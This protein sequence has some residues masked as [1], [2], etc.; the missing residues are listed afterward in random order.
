MHERNETM[1]SSKICLILAVGALALQGQ[2]ATATVEVSTVAELT[3]AVAMA[4]AGT[5][6]DGNKIGTIVLKK[7]GSFVFN[8]EYMNIDTSTTPAT[9]NLIYIY[10]KADNLVI[11]GE[12]DSSRTNWT[13]NAEPVI[14]DGNGKGRIFHDR[15]KQVAIR[16]LTLTGGSTLSSSA[17]A[18]G[19]AASAAND[20]GIDQMVFS[21]C[22]FRQNTANQYG[23]AKFATLY[24]CCVTNCSGT[25]S[26]A[27]YGKAWGCDFVGNNNGVAYRIYA[28]NCRFVSNLGATESITM[29]NEPYVISNCI[30]EANSGKGIAVCRADSVIVDSVFRGNKCGTYSV[31]WSPGAGGVTRCLFEDNGGENAT[32]GG[33]IFLNASRS[34][35]VDGCTFRRNLTRC[36][37]YGGGAILMIRTTSALGNMVVTNC[38]FEANIAS[39]KWYGAQQTECYAEGGAICN[40]T[41][42]LPSGEKPWDSLVV[43]DSTFSNNYADVAVGG[44]CGVKAERCKFKDNLRNLS[45]ETIRNLAN[46]E[47]CEARASYL[48]DCDISGGELASCVL[49]RCDIHDVCYANNTGTN[50]LCIFREFTRVTNSIVRNVSI[51]EGATGRA[52]Y[53]A[54]KVLDAEFVNCTFVSNLTT[55]MSFGGKIATTNKIDFADC[56]FHG[57]RGKYSN[58]DVLLDSAVGYPLWSEKVSFVN[59]YYGKYESANNNANVSPNSFA[60]KTGENKLMQCAE[61]KFVCQDERTMEKYPDEPLWSLTLQSPLLGMGDPLGFTADDLDLAGRPRLREDGSIDIGCY[62]CW[63]RP[64]PTGFTLLF[65]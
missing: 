41:P 60:D 22:V 47:G 59:S 20:Q 8:G 62:Q 46:R 2:A 31:I 35:T 53:A 57:N 24:D 13:Y 42:T 43:Y 61:P 11:M 3:N 28:Y 27:F 49:D 5:T 4:N 21:N 1:K 26:S 32:R 18:H 65:K 7:T 37:P 15:F 17:S 30:F 40:Y 64:K 50:A 12:D 58:S 51:H 23:A 6:I 16:N 56:L 9:T 52:L 36:D 44:V 10:D 25:S 29:L 39:N 14:I 63:I 33:A 48:V 45:T 55:T 38:T 19:G 54:T 34:T